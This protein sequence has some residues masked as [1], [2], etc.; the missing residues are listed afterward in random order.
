MPVFVLDIVPFRANA[1]SSTTS[2][3]N[4]YLVL[5]PFNS[6]D[7][8]YINRDAWWQLVLVKSADIWSP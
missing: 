1:S 6:S 7:W 5:R 2:V 8:L 4:M 3:D